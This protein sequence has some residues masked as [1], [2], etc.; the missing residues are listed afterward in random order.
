MSQR[1][2]EPV[3]A[4]QQLTRRMIHLFHACFRVFC[5]QS[6]P[7]FSVLFLFAFCAFLAQFLSFLRTN[8]RRVRVDFLENSLPILWSLVFHPATVGLFFRTD[9]RSEI[10]FF[11]AFCPNRS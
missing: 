3:F 2:Y 8:D 11:D 4:S 5:S 10:V 7:R 6:V 1:K 9:D